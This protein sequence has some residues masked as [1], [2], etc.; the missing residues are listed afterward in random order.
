MRLPVISKL[1]CCVF[2]AGL[3]TLATGT[4]RVS[5][6]VSRAVCRAKLSAAWYSKLKGSLMC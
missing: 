3:L 6:C 5:R 1:T 4:S 2:L